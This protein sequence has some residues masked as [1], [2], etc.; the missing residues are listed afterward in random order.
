MD[1]QQVGLWRQC[2]CTTVPSAWGTVLV[3]K[4]TVPQPVKKFPAFNGT[5]RLITAF[6]VTHHLSLCWAR[7]IQV[8]ALSSCVFN[9]LIS[10]NNR[11]RQQYP[12]TKIVCNMQRCMMILILSLVYARVVQSRR[13]PSYFRRRI[14]VCISV[15]PHVWLSPP[16]SSSSISLPFLY[17]TRRRHIQRY[18]VI[19]SFRFVGCFSCYW[20]TLILLQMLQ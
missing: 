12:V 18:F 2:F 3:E 7:L 15:C 4:L 11:H 10:D 16:P 6:S 8:F 19:N 1:R 5:R 20:T 9:V 13:S 14:S 17:Q